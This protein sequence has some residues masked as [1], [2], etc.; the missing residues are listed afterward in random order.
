MR[1]AILGE[2]AEVRVWR[3]KLEGMMYGG[4][5]TLEEVIAPRFKEYDKARKQLQEHQRVIGSSDVLLLLNTDGKIGPDTYCCLRMGWLMGKRLFALREP[6][7][8]RKE[9]REMGLKKWNREFLGGATDT[10]S[11][12]TRSQE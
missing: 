10:P 7:N 3:K 4:F 8:F 5:N 9:L 12:D 2:E 1:I 11:T 6:H